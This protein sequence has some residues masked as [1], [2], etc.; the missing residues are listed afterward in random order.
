MEDAGQGEVLEQ[1]TGHGDTTQ[2][3]KSGGSFS[4]GLL[5]SLKPLT[6]LPNTLFIAYAVFV[7]FNAIRNP[8]A[9]FRP[10]SAWSV[11]GYMAMFFLPLAAVAVYN[12]SREKVR[13]TGNIS[14][15]VT[16]FFIV[17]SMVAELH[18][19]TRNRQRMV[20]RELAVLNAQ[21]ATQ[22]AAAPYIN[23][24]PIP[25]T[26]MSRDGSVSAGVSIK[27]GKLAVPFNDYISLQMSAE[28]MKT[29]TLAD[30]AIASVVAVSP[31]ELHVTGKGKGQ[32]SLSIL[33]SAGYKFAYTVDV[34]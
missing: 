22:Q 25:P 8:I 24:S 20:E 10:E 6:S 16:V 12:A 18:N 5:D 1:D 9:V 34:E 3:Q 31:Y 21:R 11:I 15:A 2:A 32:T 17:F 7:A 26:I 13:A 28:P 4:K 29:V 33:D 30:P 27:D 23:N 19:E 14:V